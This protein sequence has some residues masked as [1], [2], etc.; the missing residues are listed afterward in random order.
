LNA[1]R[2]SERETQS[3]GYLVTFALLLTVIS[4]VVYQFLERPAERWV[5]VTLDSPGGHRVDL[6]G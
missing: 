5:R 4:L 6:G 1:W 3:V 2:P